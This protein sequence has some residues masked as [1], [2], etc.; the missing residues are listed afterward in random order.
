MGGILGLGLLDLAQIGALLGLERL[1]E[2]AVLD[3]ADDLAR[4]FERAL[5]I[6][7]ALRPDEMAELR[8]LRGPLHALEGAEVAAVFRPFDRFARG[9]EVEDDRLRRA[10]RL[11]Q[12]LIG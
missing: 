6:E 12:R 10:A 3:V 5:A 4:P 1:V 11:E 2:A 8:G 7:V 9:V